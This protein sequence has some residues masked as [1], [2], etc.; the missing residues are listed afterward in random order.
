[1]SEHSNLTGI[2]CDVQGNNENRPP[3]R[4]RVSFEQGVINVLE[5]D[6]RNIKQEH[7][8]AYE[9]GSFLAKEKILR[10]IED[11]NQRSREKLRRKEEK[12]NRKDEVAR[13]EERESFEEKIRI[14]RKRNDDLVK[15]NSD[16]AEKNNDLVK[17]N[18]AMKD[19]LDLLSK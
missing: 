17:K 8:R 15:K 3:K 18:N 4:P 11:E 6:I 13:K 5:E 12:R 16:L 2:N 19:E 1:M 9:Y 14:L 10:E 7:D